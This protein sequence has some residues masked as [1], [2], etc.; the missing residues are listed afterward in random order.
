MKKLKS[1]LLIGS[2]AIAAI[3][4][5]A[6]ANEANNQAAQ[7]TDAMNM[8]NPAAW[9]TM[10][11]PGMPGQ[12]PAG[13][14][15]ATANPYAAFMTPTNWANPY[16][17]MAFMN[18]Q[19]WGSMMNPMTYMM[20]MNPATYSQMMNPMAYMNFMNPGTY[21]PAMDPNSYMAG[22]MQMFSMIQNEE[23]IPTDFWSFLN[24][25]STDESTAQSGN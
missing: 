5:P 9:F 18:P 7:Q 22:M 25:Q 15:A 12:Y 3:A 23:S 1:I 4:G 20:F 6:F 17:Y 11:Q 2:I 13:Q 21:A 14:P 24:N 8:F 10:M 16:S 19:S